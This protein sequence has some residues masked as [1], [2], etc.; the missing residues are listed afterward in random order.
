MNAELN[1]EMNEFIFGN[2]VKICAKM[3][4]IIVDSGRVFLQHVRECCKNVFV[5]WMVCLYTVDK[6]NNVVLAVVVN[7]R[8]RVFG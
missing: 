5:W 2:F 7:F 4:N 8:G 3:K 1:E 6:L